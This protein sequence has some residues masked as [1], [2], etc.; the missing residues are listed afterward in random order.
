M[1]DIISGKTAN[2][3]WKQAA[4]CLFLKNNYID[5]RNGKTREMMHTLLT[6]ENPRQKW[7]QGRKPPISISFALA[8]LVWIM[9]GEDRSDIINYWNPC[10]PQYAGR[11]T[12]YYGAYGKRIRSHFGFDQLKKAYI[13]LQG[14]P[15][16]RQVVIQI[17]D[18]QKDFP[19]EDG[20]PRNEDIP[21][22]VCS[23]LKIRD[24][25]LEW[26][27]I[28]RSNDVFL[29]LPYNFVQFMSIQEI[30]AGWLNIEVGTYNHYSDSLHLYANDTKKMG[31]LSE[32]EIENQD[33]IS[34]NFDESERLFSEIFRRMQ[35]LMDV[36]L[37][38]KDIER[39]GCLESEYPAYNNIMVLVAAYVAHKIRDKDLT[40]TLISRC[41]N[42]LYVEMWNRWENSKKNKW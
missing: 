36:N 39:I 8:E 38:E 17:F 23:L 16:S 35:Y 29:G 7:V 32:K 30:L 6:V 3:V 21:C 20:K 25:R 4:E 26:T 27:Q 22:N 41:S 34:L 18:A 31:I 11:G 37:S 12:H 40:R 42:N 24:N 15:E 2:E 14:C 13:A 5:G 9:C 1:A 19:V 28:L 33:N 10:L